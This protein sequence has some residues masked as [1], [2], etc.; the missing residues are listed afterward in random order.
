MIKYYL[1]GGAIRDR[2]L[3]LS[4][5]DYDFVA[6]GATPEFFLEKGFKR[7]GNDFPVFLEPKNQWEVAIARIE[8]KTGIGYS[9]FDTIWDGVTLKEDL[10]RRDLTINTLAQEVDFEQSVLKGEPVVIGDIIDYFGGVTDLDSKILNPVS[11]AFMEDPVRLLRTARFYA[12]YMFEPLPKVFSYGLSMATFGELKALTPERVWKETEKA[13]SG[14]NVSKYFEFLMCFNNFPFMNIFH[15]MDE[16]VEN[17]K[18][19]QESNV[20]I[21]TMLVL[22]YANEHYNDTEINLACLL[23]DI[24]K[25][26]CYKENGNGYNHDTLGVKMIEDWCSKWKIPNNYKTLAKI[27][28]QQHQK[29]HSVLGRDKNRRSKPSSIMRLFEQSGALA[30]PDRFLK[31]LNVCEADHFGRVSSANSKVYKQKDYLKECLTAVLSLDT[32][33]ISAKM[34][35]QGK[36]GIAIGEAIRVARIDE[37]RK[38]YKNWR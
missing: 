34:L 36:N 35:A 23:H 3:G 33:V 14:Q 27:T 38:I 11:V 18:H 25:P 5:N 21:H 19:H 9:C 13:L 16:C 30:K 17:N 6:V 4:V 28:C 2:L 32:K 26:K 8:Q 7:V 22:N 31:V 15:E 20:F 12:K 10:F 24:A 1:V 37:I 29:I